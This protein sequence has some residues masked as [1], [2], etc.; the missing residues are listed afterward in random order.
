MKLVSKL[1]AKTSVTNAKGCAVS[2]AEFTRNSDNAPTCLIAG[3]PVKLESREYSTGSF[4]YM[5]ERKPTIN[6]T[7]DN[8]TIVQCT[9]DVKLYVVNS[10]L[11]PR[12]SD[13]AS[14]LN[15]KYVAKLQGEDA[16]D[17]SETVG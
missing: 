10:K 6:V 3:Q 16:G 8:G 5:L 11:A 9:A 4:G 7:L 14:V 17:D 13:D 1:P 2:F 12:N 15:P